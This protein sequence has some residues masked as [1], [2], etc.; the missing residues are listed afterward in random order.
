M[1]SAYNHDIDNNSI[2]FNIHKNDYSPHDLWKKFFSDKEI[3]VM[4]SGGVDSQFS[5]IL[6][7]D[8]AAKTRTII[9]KLLWQNYC[10]NAADVIAAIDFCYQNNY[11]FVVE[12]FELS[13][14]LDTHD[15][16]SFCKDNYLASPQHA[17]ILYYILHNKNITPSETVLFGGEV[18]IF[19]MIND[20]MSY[21]GLSTN[22]SKVDVDNLNGKIFTSGH[23]P[24][25]IF[26]EKYGFN[27][28]RDPFL[29]SP[30]IF[31]SSLVKN[32]EII[33]ENNQCPQI[34][35]NNQFSVLKQHVY[36]QKILY[37]TNLSNKF[38]LPLTK[39]TGYELLRFHL[40][41][42]TGNYDE[43]N[44]RYRSPLKQNL[45]SEKP[46]IVYS[47]KKSVLEL[48]SICEELVKT[49]SAVNN[50]IWNLDF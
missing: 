37:Y 8:Y 7:N 25:L 40:A 36:M 5:C 42:L 24:Y 33:K 43:F 45:L 9:I 13:N 44:D 31:Y 30:E 17:V 4:L 38:L 20:K 19:R 22:N 47:N 14:R 49:N 15:F 23:T 2:I 6:A 39:R 41:S 46:Y 18:P 10:V 12:E 50:T 35:T 26:A 3:V 29:I 32:I 21:V 34:Y 27:F 16:I 11:E 1:T 28:C 48:L